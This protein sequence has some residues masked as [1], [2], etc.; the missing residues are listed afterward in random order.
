MKA[1]HTRLGD[2]HGLLD[3]HTS[4]TV[5]SLDPAGRLALFYGFFGGEEHVSAEFRDS[6]RK[7]GR[8][9][10]SYPQLATDVHLGGA[11][12]GHVVRE[13]FRGRLSRSGRYAI[14]LHEL[15]DDSLAELADVRAERR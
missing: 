11:L 12:V 2:V 5:G 8:E 15:I 7:I 1:P 9:L 14:D 3:P 4:K 13:I 6:V 10:V